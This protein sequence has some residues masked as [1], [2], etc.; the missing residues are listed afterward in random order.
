MATDKGLEE[1]P[2]SESSLTCAP[3]N[4]CAIAER[5]PGLGTL[6]LQYRK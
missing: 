4:V 3:N 2:E 1:I 5:R 6:G